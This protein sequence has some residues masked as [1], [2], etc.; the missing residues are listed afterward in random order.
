MTDHLGFRGVFVDTGAFGSFWI[1]GEVNFHLASRIM[2]GIVEANLAIVTTNFIIAETHA[3]VLSR[4][5]RRAAIRALDFIDRGADF[6]ERVTEGDEKEARI[7][8]EKYDDKTF[9]YT[10]ATSFAVMDRLK[11]REVFTFDRHFE[12]F[13]FSPLKPS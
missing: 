12:Q 6:I 9:S 8:L 5:G 10:D 13:G 2:N 11:L 1:E 4:S 7:I 3:L